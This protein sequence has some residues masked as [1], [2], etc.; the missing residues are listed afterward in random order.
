MNFEGFISEEQAQE[1]VGVIARIEDPERPENVWDLICTEVCGLTSLTRAALFTFERSLGTIVPVGSYGVD[2]DVLKRV[3]G[4]LDEMPLAVKLLAGSPPIEASSNLDLAKALE[5]ELPKRYAG[6]ATLASVTCSPLAIGGR[7]FGLIVGDQGGG[8]YVLSS[9]DQAT[10]ITLGRL[11]AMAATVERSTINQER[12]KSLEAR[13]DLMREIHDH[14][15]Q[16]LFGVSLVL[17]TEGEF[18]ES[19]RNRCSR[20]ISDVLTQLR[21]MLGRPVAS[22]N[23]EVSRTLREL[24]DSLD[25]MGRITFTWQEGIETPSELERLAQSVVLEAIRNVEKHSNE[26]SI[27]VRVFLEAGTFQIEV[28]NDNVNEKPDG[29]EKVGSGGIGLRLLT[30]E[31]LQYNALVESG[32]I[33]G[34]R[35]RVRLKAPV[36][37]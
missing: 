21:T 20:E 34:G 30:L 33:G 32:P 14:V 9:E 13:I 1:M 19:D 6:P 8:E 22:S 25:D 10:V 35:W 28:E 24:L 4:A 16:K 26:G 3:E 23:I 29:A 12:T 27:E 37:S 15:I 18:S 17:A 11:A 36:T 5:Y 7:W 2:D 31:A